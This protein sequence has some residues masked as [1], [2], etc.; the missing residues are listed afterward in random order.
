[1]IPYESHIIYHCSALPYLVLAGGSRFP[2][3]P[4]HKPNICFV[5]Q[6]VNV[7]SISSWSLIKSWRG[8]DPRRTPGIHCLVMDSNS[9]LWHWSPCFGLRCSAVFNPPP[10]LSSPYFCNL[11]LRILQETEPKPFHKIRYPVS[12]ALPSSAL[13]HFMEKTQSSQAW[14]PLCESLLTTFNHLLV[15]HVPGNGFQN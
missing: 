5:R 4:L 7:F 14:L 12:T 9:T 13:R 11:S 1:M 10:C 8:L 2:L 3:L 15:P 6:N